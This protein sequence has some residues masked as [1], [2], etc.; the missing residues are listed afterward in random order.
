VGFA[1]LEL[2]KLSVHSFY[3]D[4]VKKKLAKDASVSFVA[5]DTDSLVLKISGVGDLTN[6]Y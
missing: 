5:S 6:R 2:S 4:C 3:Y 1:I